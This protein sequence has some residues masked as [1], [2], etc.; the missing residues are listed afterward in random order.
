VETL[1]FL[2][3]TAAL[4]LIL[5]FSLKNDLLRPGEAETGWFRIRQPGNMP[6]KP[7]AAP[8]RRRVL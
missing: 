3:D 1:L 4:L 7:S 5:L 6:E 8:A 2:I